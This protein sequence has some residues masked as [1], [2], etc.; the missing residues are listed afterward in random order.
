MRERQ[1][2]S[3]VAGIAT[4]IIALLLSAC[5]DN[6]GKVSEHLD[7]ANR[8]LER[9]NPGAAVIELKSA[10]QLNPENIQARLTLGRIYLA[11]RRGAAAQKELVTARRLGSQDAQLAVDIARSMVMAGEFDEALELAGNDDLDT[12]RWKNVS[13]FALLGKNQYEPAR[14]AFERALELDETDT[15]ARRGLARPG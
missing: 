5:S 2:G 8:Y 7:N 14:T 15:E 12:A 3:R 13:G 1:T 6:T 9:S 11:Q 10:L 4:I